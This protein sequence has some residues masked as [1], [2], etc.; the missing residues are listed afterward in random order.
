[1]DVNV[2]A[3]DTSGQGA[4]S[5]PVS[6]VAEVSCV[7]RVSRVSRAAWNFAQ[8]D[9]VWRQFRPQTPYGKDF[10]AEKCVYA[11]TEDLMSAYEDV[12]VYGEFA[13]SCLVDRPQSAALD[14]IQWHLGRIP[15]LPPFELSS[16]GLPS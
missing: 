11:C 16:S 5:V 14:K 2:R 12:R 6:G 15:R 9:E 7:S 10:A 1:M 8:M 13:T 4:T 3:A